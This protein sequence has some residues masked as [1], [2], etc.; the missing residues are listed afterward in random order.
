MPSLKDTK[1]RIGSVKNTQKYTRYEI[2]FVCKYVE[3]ICLLNATIIQPLLDLLQ[4]VIACYGLDVP[5]L[6]ERKK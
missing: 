2:G 5:L 1:R 3:K 6:E 4:Q